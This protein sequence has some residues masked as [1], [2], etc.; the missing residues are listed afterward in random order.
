MSDNLEA[1]NK[2]LYEHLLAGSTINFLQA[3]DMGIGYLNSRIS[4]LR[5]VM[6]IHSRFIRINGIQCKEYSLAPFDESAGGSDRY[7]KSI[8]ASR[9]AE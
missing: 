8:I 3:R 6:T 1:Q 2:R 7:Y 5:K 4:D 9:R